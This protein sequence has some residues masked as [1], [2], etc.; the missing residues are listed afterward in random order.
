MLSDV[1]DI[2]GEIS[3]LITFSPKREK[4]LVK[5]KEQTKNTEQIT[6]NKTTK[7]STTRWTVRKLL[8]HYGT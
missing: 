7:L 3:V 2:T 4:L 1:M 6:P 5:L 8:V